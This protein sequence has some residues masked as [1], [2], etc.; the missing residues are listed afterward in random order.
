M[1]YA[2][3]AHE[4]LLALKAEL[5][6]AYGELKARNLK[7]NMA[8]GKPGGEQLK[9]SL[10]MLDC[11][12]SDGD[13]IASDGTDCCNY[14][15]LDGIPEAKTFMAEMM[16]HDPANVC[17]FG[18]SSLNIMYDLVAGGVLYGYSGEPA[19]KDQGT[20]K[21]LCPSPGYDRHFRIC[22]TLGMEL[23]PIELRADGPDMDKV[24]ELVADPAVKGIWCVP[25]YS[26]PTGTTYSD[27]VVKRLA[28]MPVAAKDFRIF[29]DNA[30]CV[31]DLYDETERRERVLDIARTCVAAGN[32]DRY[33][34]FASTSKVTLPGAGIAAVAASADNIAVI[35]KR[36]GTETVG[37]DKLNQLR[38]VKFLKDRA[39]LDE[40]MKK[41]AAII[42]PKFEL[43]VNTLAAELGETGATWSTPNGGYF[44]SFD[45]APN[46]AQRTVQLAKEAGV[47]MTGAGATWPYGKDPLDRNIRIAPTLPPLEELEQALEVFCC[48][49]KLATVESLLA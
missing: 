37:Y 8:R 28:S 42:R 44:I 31:H 3:L 40:H 48:S 27:E 24:E 38:H 12:T 29:W 19:W 25:Q 13:L 43:V 11:V 21:W 32:P 6:E 5:E 47:V 46:T 45:G 39:G 16:D 18:N 15:V 22:E 26:N 30:Y 1:A 41:H 14:G 49:A 23:I 2:D 36:I 10:P 34:K 35:R 7:L 20:I 17:V 33:F 4:E 9:L